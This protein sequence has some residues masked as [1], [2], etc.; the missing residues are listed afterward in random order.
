M[1]IDLMINGKTAQSW[2]IPED[3]IDMTDGWDMKAR[4]DHRKGVIER[5][6]KSMEN[7]YIDLLVQMKG[8]AWFEVVLGSKVNCLEISD[9]EMNEFEF[10]TEH[11]I[12]QP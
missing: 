2:D 10:L 3:N 4:H 12:K 1:K 8:K 6:V 5:W 9:Q 7:A 11:I